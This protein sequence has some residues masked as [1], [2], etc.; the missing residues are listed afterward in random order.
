MLM[1]QISKSRS[2]NFNL[3]ITK[4]SSYHNLV[5]YQFS[6]N[7]ELVYYALKIIKNTNFCRP[8]FAIFQK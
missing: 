1:A 4:D 2:R 6:S 5:D 7:L 3:N 8:N